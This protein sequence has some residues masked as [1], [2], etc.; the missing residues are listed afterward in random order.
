MGCYACQ[1]EFGDAIARQE[2]TSS[3]LVRMCRYVLFV[4][5]FFI[6]LFAI[7]FSIALFLRAMGKR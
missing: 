7:E 4:V 1:R 2:Q 6:I 3:K 5:L